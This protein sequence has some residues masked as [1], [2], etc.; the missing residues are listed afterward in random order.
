MSEKLGT[1]RLD[2][3]SASASD[4]ARRNARMAARRAEGAPIAAIAEEFG[5]ARSTVQKGLADHARAAP[6][7]DAVDVGAIVASGLR[8]HRAALARATELL[9]SDSPNVV[10]GAGNAISRLLGSFVSTL[11]ALGAI[12][13]PDFERAKLRLSLEAREVAGEMV[14]AVGRFR[15]AVARVE[16]ANPELEGATDE[17]VR[18]FERV[19]AE[20]PTPTLLGPEHFGPGVDRLDA[21]PAPPPERPRPRELVR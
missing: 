10:L 5:V 13:D 18:T 9:D 15:A 20:P 14:A 8:A 6:L 16:A 3:G 21:R 11:R 1:S 2:P 17:L 19:L 7:E 4:R 12:G